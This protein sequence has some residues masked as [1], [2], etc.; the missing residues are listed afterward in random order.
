M[1]AFCGSTPTHAPAVFW[2][3]RATI[4]GQA[5]VPPAGRLGREAISVHRRRLM[6][7]PDPITE[8][9]AATAVLLARQTK[10]SVA[11]PVDH[12]A[13]RLQALVAVLKVKFRAG[14]RPARRM[15]RAV[16]LV[17]AVDLIGDH[18]RGR[19]M[20]RAFP[21]VVAADSIV[22]P[23]P[24]RTLGPLAVQ[25]PASHLDAVVVLIVA[26]DASALPTM[27]L[28]AAAASHSGKLCAFS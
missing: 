24:H 18:S 27:L 25:L 7:R 28:A 4:A 23:S 14:R 9:R 19:K 8:L 22:E 20:P 15:L 17:A 11:H 3:W 26:L 12:L 5:R 16:L 13:V 10:D 2:A 1:V 6:G 21:L